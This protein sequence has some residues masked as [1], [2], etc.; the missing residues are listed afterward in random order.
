MLGPQKVI[1]IFSFVAGDLLVQDHQDL[2]L[3]HQKSGTCIPSSITVSVLERAMNQVKIDR[4]VQKTFLCFAWG[5][6]GGGKGALAS[7]SFKNNVFAW[8]FGFKPPWIKCRE[9][10]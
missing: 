4:F 3:E 6:S 1:Q 10:P 9:L 5:S 8:I 2:V 7:I